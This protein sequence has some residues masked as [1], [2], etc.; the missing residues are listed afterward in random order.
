MVVNLFI[1]PMLGLMLSG[2]L[3][4]SAWLDQDPARNLVGRTIRTGSGRAYPGFGADGMAFHP[5][6]H[7]HRCHPAL[8]DLVTT[9]TPARK[10]PVF[11][12]RENPVDVAT[13]RRRT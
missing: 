8:R 11:K 12:T 9:M 1:G 2:N 6:L 3:A 13:F 4:S 5:G 7:V 10:E